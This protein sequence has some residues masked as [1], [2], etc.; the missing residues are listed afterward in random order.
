VNIAT[1]AETLWSPESGVTNNQAGIW[2]SG[3]GL[4]SDG[5]GRIFL[6]SGNGV[7]PT[8]HAGTSPGGQLAESVIRLAVNSNGTLG[9][10][11]IFSPANAP[12]LDASDV[13]YGAG[14]PVGVPFTVAGYNALAQIGKDG[15][16][17]LLNR[18]G[19]GGREQGP[20]STD[21]PCSSAR[22]MAASGVILRSSETPRR[23]RPT[24]A[25]QTPTMT[26]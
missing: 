4:M 24:Q 17:W 25:P 11:D 21:T 16:I 2:Q 15:R 7:S 23:P 22:L 10:Q 14:G 12:S 1:G 9:A 13:D 5:S 20:N 19:L 26:S 3:A 6:T 18:S 8:K